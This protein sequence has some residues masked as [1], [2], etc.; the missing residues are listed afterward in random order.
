[1]SEINLDEQIEEWSW[2]RSDFLTFFAHPKW[3][4]PRTGTHIFFNDSHWSVSIL[5]F[6]VCKTG[7]AQVG[8]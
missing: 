6:S 2:K 7:L 5:Q 4:D 3:G 8:K 1:M